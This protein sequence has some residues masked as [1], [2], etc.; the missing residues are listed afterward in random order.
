[1][2]GSLFKTQI[3]KIAAGGAG[4][5]RLEG[6]SAFIEGSAPGETVLCRV[7]AE[8][9]SW[10]QAELL[11]IV[12]SS[13]DRVQ[14]VCP[15]WGKCG[16]CNLQHLSYSA[17][18]AAKTAILKEA[19]VRIGG[20]CPPQPMVSP[21]EP[22]EY[23]NRMQFHAVRQGQK[24]EADALW[25][26]KA[27]KKGD[28]ISVADCPI[29]DP[30]IRAVLRGESEK[31]QSQLLP[32]G[33]DRFT[34]YAR[35]GLFLSEGGASRG[36][37]RVLDRELVLDAGAFFQSNGAML[38][39]LIIDLREIVNGMTDNADRTLP[40]ADLYCGVGTFAAF[41]G[42]M[43]SHVDL[44]EEHT[45]ALA[46]A[47]ENL[48]HLTSADFFAQRGEHWAHSG[49]SRR[50][51]FICADPPRQGLDPA[52]ARRLAADGPPLLAYISCDPA[53]LARDSALLTAGGYKLAELRWYDFYPQTAHI[54]SLALFV[55]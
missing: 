44:V 6:K 54:E 14:P 29:A 51:G 19:F 36:K 5:A 26:L 47:R 11:E 40:M 31:T 50:Y 15:L 10:L 38:E 33:Q 28:V 25:G 43:F 55:R 20:F 49:F 30:G 39:K 27:R 48:T 16:G 45:T 8:H 7:T 23:R 34:V 2:T 41:L 24:G 46:L 1:M 4:L 18:L 53:T 52:L 37:T 9:R 32:P 13:P 22:W 17:Q 42:D 21:A 3:E 35:G 12:E